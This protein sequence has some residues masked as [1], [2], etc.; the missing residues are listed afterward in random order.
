M[1]KATVRAFLESFAVGD[2]YGKATEQCT[3]QEIEARYEHIDTLLTPEAS[4]THEDLFHGQ[5][6]DDT[7]QVVYLV[8]EYAKP[9]H[10]TPYH[11]AMCLL[12][13]VTE[14]DA[15]NKYIGTNSL[16]ALRAIESGADV[17][18]TGLNGI[19]CGGMMRVPAAFFFS[20]PE[21][22][23]GNVVHCLVPTHNTSVAME[24]AM[25]Y[26]FALQAA[27]RGA[28][29]DEILSE[30]CK[31]AEIGKV[32]GSHL[33]TAAVAPSCAERIR[34]LQR[35]IP[36][37]KNEQELK[38]FLYDILGATQASCDCCACAFALFQWAREDVRLAVRLATEMGGDTD[39]IACLA[40]GLC[41]MYAGKHNLPQEMVEL[42]AQA[43]HLD[44]DA[45]AETIMAARS[46]WEG[47]E[48]P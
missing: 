14:T 19:T 35:V 17:T 5:V 24:S 12:R 28:E 1:N 39:T 45:L 23:V 13:W 9:G 40:A 48:T 15:A 43:N 11:T 34:F 27:D 7:E 29:M 16:N 33:R 47:V 42:V 18:T 31:G 32:Y 26:A 41:A 2:A 44:F 25:C 38:H 20:R 21:N 8:R 37:M 46:S 10:L 3:R 6:T 4:L 22:L 36:T 30:A